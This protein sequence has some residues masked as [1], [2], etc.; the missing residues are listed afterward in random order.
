MHWR[1]CWE[2]G[3]VRQQEALI[4]RSEA[5]SGCRQ[6]VNRV[7]LRATLAAEAAGSVGSRREGDLCIWTTLVAVWHTW[8]P[9]SIPLTT[10]K[11]TPCLALL[12]GSSLSSLLSAVSKEDGT[13]KAQKPNVEWVELRRRS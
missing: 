2:G 5:G 3:D 9:P 4:A 12:V 7:S 11:N 8:L 6:P 10:E 13:A 1:D